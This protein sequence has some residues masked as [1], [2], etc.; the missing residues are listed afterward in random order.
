MKLCRNLLVQKLTSSSIMPQFLSKTEKKLKLFIK[1]IFN[2]EKRKLAALNYIFCR[3]KRVRQ[4]N[5]EYLGH[6]Y[7]TDIITFEFSEPG[8][9]VISDV[10]ISVDRVKENTVSHET[11]LNEEV[12]RV[13]FHGALHL[14]GYADKTAA[15]KKRMRKRED[16]YLSKFT[17]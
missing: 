3:D 2:Q 5:K 12:H 7:F 13:M 11:S 16:F 4:I 6:D 17:S 15:E 9:P 10:Y 1:F 8:Q 14:C